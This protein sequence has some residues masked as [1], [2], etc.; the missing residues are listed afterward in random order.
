[1]KGIEA[2]DW[3]RLHELYAIDAIVEHPFALPRPT[4]LSGRAEIRTHFERFALQ[5]LQLKVRDMNFHTATDPEVVVVEWQYEGFVTTTRHAFSV[6]NAQ[7]SRVRN[8][9]I[10]FSRDYHNHALMA[11]V[12]G[13]LD[14]LYTALGA[15]VP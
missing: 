7:I 10:V 12:S 9:E 15:L 5:P 14:A 6:A 13:R 3:P 1:M 8:G 4:R 11:A 2:R